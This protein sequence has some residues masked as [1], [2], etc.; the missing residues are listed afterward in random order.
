MAIRVSQSHF[1][2]N[3]CLQGYPPAIHATVPPHLTGFLPE[4]FGNN[5]KFQVIEL[6][7]APL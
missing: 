5:D 7:C 4:D 6:H 2:G 3:M 1:C